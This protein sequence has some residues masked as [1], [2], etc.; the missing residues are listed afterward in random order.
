MLAHISAYFVRQFIYGI[1]SEK[2]NIGI[3]P[4]YDSNILKKMR[5][6]HSC[7]YYYYY[8][9]YQIFDRAIPTGLRPSYRVP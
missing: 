6:K 1:L 8:Y 4:A 7:Y 9:Y 5:T 2:G 3:E